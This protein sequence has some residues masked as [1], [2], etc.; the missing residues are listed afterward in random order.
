MQAA[1]SI[2]SLAGVP[3]QMVVNRDQSR[4]AD[5]A[6]GMA[7]AGLLEPR[8]WERR[9]TWPSEICERAIATW[10]ERTVP[11]FEIVPQLYCHVTCEVMQ[12]FGDTQQTVPQMVIVHVGPRGRR[13]ASHVTVERAIRQL[14]QDC[15]GWGYRVL[16]HIEE[17][18]RATALMFTPFQA[19]VMASHVYWLGEMDEKWALQNAKEEGVDPS[20]IDIYTAARF[21]ERIPREASSR[22]PRVKRA[23]LP[24]SGTRYDRTLVQRCDR[25]RALARSKAIERL[26]ELDMRR[27]DP[28][29]SAWTEFAAVV[30]WNENDDAIRIA[31]DWFNAVYQEYTWETFGS[32][33]VST[34]PTALRRFLDDMR[35]WMALL[36]ETDA[37]LAR[38]GERI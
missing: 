11:R 24:P 2:P 14:E 25:I 36:A 33:S 3:M 27:Q 29:G 28:D 26:H 21:H 7:Q 18:A 5:L 22:L 32:W 20:E 34:Q 19:F 30:R 35:T 17:G 13:S 1:L 38:I 10:W 16:A 31:D 15:P 37:L 23:W 4:A 6:L 9:W 12:P 8:H